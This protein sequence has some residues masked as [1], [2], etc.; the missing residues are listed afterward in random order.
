M[1]HVNEHVPTTKR[2][3][4]HVG[5]SQ[6]S[7]LASFELRNNEGVI[8]LMKFQLRDEVCDALPASAAARLAPRPPL[9]FDA[10]SVLPLPISFPAV[11]PPSSS[12]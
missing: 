9:R 8:F 5:F 11:T 4:N 2:N 12:P 1:M 3:I 7:F 6:T 10:A